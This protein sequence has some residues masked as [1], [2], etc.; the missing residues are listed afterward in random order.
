MDSWRPFSSPVRSE[1]GKLL[2]EADLAQEIR[3]LR[4]EVRQMREL[5]DLLV[6]LVVE[7]D[8]LD[9]D[10]SELILTVGAEIPR[11]NN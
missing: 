2:A 5:I 3:V 1:G 7:S 4:E 10:E 11:L 8:D 6:A 9:E